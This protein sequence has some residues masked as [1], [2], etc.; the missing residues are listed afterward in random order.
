MS[1]ETAMAIQL[2]SA[3]PGMEYIPSLN[4]LMRQTEAVR[5]AEH[6]LRTLDE[7]K[8]LDENKLSSRAR[9]GLKYYDELQK[10]IPRNEMDVWNVSMLVW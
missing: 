6:G 2:F 10:K 7:L 9:I 5:H 1:D 4:F 8:L 3:I